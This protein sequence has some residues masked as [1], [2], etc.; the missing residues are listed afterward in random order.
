MAHSHRRCGLRFGARRCGTGNWKDIGGR[1][2]LARVDQP[3][4]RCVSLGHRSR[5]GPRRCA[6]APGRPTS[7]SS[8]AAGTGRCWA[9]DTPKSAC[10][11]A[12]LSRKGRQHEFPAD[13]PLF[14]CRCT[15]RATPAVVRPPRC[16]R[17]R[18]PGR[19][20]SALHVRAV[21][22]RARARDAV[23][24]ISR[25]RQ[26]RFHVERRGFSVDGPRGWPLEWPLPSSATS[27]ASPSSAA[28]Q[29]PDM[30]PARRSG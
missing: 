6:P 20:S 16:R 19:S 2:A 13:P 10:E 7:T 3:P 8:S 17:A 28:A 9:P 12:P 18:R 30:K 5:P 26:P 27:V 4:E 21:P 15:H 1:E 24:A 11:T 25:T 14:V 22:Q 29:A 23:A